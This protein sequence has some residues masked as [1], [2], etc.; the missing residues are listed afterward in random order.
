MPSENQ[1]LTYTE[2]PNS[3]S[4]NYSDQIVSTAY[5]TSFEQYTKE[6]YVRPLLMLGNALEILHQLPNSCIDFV[7]TSPPY[8]GKREYE[9]GGIGLEKDYRDYVS[10]LA[11]IAI[12]IKRVL[13]NE[14]SFWLN[15]GDSYQNKSLLGIPWHIAF[16]LTEKQGWILRN[17]VIWNKVKSGMDNTKDR[18]GNVHENVFH[19]VKQPKYYYNA[20][21]IRSKP[22]EAK[23]VNGAVVSATGVSGVRYKRQ[24]E[25]STSL[26]QKE[27]VEAFEA[28]EKM[29]AD[30]AV[31][32]ISDFRMVIRGQQRATH[33]DSEKVSGRAKE[34]RNKGFYF[35]RYHPKGSKPADVWDIIPEDTQKRDAHFAPYPEDLCLI[36]ILA[37]CPEGGIILDPFCGTGTTLVVAGNLG[38]KSVGIDLSRQ[39]LELSRKRCASLL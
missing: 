33:S 35:L 16:E 20:D 21:A 1:V 9:N 38:R 29:L 7:M 18:L 13:K 23:V 34:L 26:N 39:Y 22:R 27:K 19:F 10:N 30:I 24:I 3:V 4:L 11:D 8:W 14:G 28:L 5:R 2:D 32:R 17:S 31:G 25:L 37:T 6:P 15:I 36:P 12:E